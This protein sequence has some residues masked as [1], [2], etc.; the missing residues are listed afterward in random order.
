[1]EGPLSPPTRYPNTILKPPAGRGK[2][3]I[4]TVRKESLASMPA[5]SSPH[6]SCGNPR[7]TRLPRKTYS[8]AALFPVI[9]L[10]TGCTRLKMQIVTECKFSL[11]EKIEGVQQDRSL[12]AS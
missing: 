7:L 12:T 5:L 4:F 9:G 2:C 10:W 1:M 11:T 3:A 6:E 8:A